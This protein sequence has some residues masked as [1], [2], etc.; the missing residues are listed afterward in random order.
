MSCVPT[1]PAQLTVTYRVIVTLHAPVNA[2]QLH[3][4]VAGGALASPA[5]TRSHARVN[6]GAHVNDDP[7]SSTTNGPSN[8]GGAV[9]HVEGSAHF[10]P[11]GCASGKG[12]MPPSDAGES[13]D[14]SAFSPPSAV[15]SMVVKS[16]APTRLA[17]PRKI[18]PPQSPSSNRRRIATSVAR[19]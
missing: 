10:G 1:T 18:A 19:S 7:C 9:M 15:G 4:H 5:P 6:A 13:N 3:V 11:S 16:L 2:P 8:P 12:S 14:A 17:Q